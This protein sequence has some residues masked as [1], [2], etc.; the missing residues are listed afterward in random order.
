VLV[1]L[2][3]QVRV[4]VRVREPV[5]DEHAVGEDGRRH[6]GDRPVAAMRAKASRIVNRTRVTARS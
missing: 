1:V 3:G 5:E 4:D 2:A 6:A